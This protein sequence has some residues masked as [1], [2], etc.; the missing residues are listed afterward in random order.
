MQNYEITFIGWNGQVEREEVFG[1]T[2]L[3]AFIFELDQNEAVVIKVRK[4]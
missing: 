2:A 4:L 1:M 3:A